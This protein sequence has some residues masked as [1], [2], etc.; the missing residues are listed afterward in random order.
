MRL[1]PVV[2][3]GSIQAAWRQGDHVQRNKL[4]DQLARVLQNVSE[5]E[6]QALPDKDPEVPGMYDKLC[7]MMVCCR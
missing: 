6:A 3:A 7:S 2:C 1:S 4:L 5:D